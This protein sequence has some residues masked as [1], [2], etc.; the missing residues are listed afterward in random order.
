MG[1]GPETPQ[2]WVLRG[3]GTGSRPSCRQSN[4]SSTF[5]YQNRRCSPPRVPHSAC[6]FA[7]A[8][9]EQPKDI[10]KT[11]ERPNRCPESLRFVRLAQHCGLANL[12]MRHGRA[13]RPRRFCTIIRAVAGQICWHLCCKNSMA[14]AQCNGPQKLAGSMQP[15]CCQKFCRFRRHNRAHKFLQKLPR[16]VLSLKA[17]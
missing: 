5:G 15:D 11:A 2:D 10:A 6:K 9:P 7:R 12:G 16:F 14:A 8:A 13:A 1:L 17:I 4:P 3:L